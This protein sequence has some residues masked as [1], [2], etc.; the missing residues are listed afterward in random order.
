MH[1][2]EILPPGKH[3]VVTHTC[4]I[5]FMAHRTGSVGLKALLRKCMFMFYFLFVCLFSLDLSN[6]DLFSSLALCLEPLNYF[7]S[8]AWT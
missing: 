3:I 2:G 6:F 8:T 1:L 5:Q 7:P 4:A